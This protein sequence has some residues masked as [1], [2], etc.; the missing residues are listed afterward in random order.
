MF[1]MTKFL[2]LIVTSAVLLYLAPIVPALA[3]GADAAAEIRELEQRVEDA[4]VKRHL[5]FLDSVYADDFRFTH[6]DGTVRSKAE[7]LKSL[8]N[9]RF[10]SREISSL[11]VEIHGNVAVAAGRLDIA[12]HAENGERKYS[13]RYVRVYQRRNGKWKMLMQ[14][15]VSES[16]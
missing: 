14:R 10:I 2:R 9:T 8:T 5:E 4:T 11:E 16:L 12:R 1:L 3:G 13:L 7:S 6:A 15:I